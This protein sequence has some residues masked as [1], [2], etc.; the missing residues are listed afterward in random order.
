MRNWAGRKEFSEVI[1]MNKLKFTETLDLALN[2]TPN[3]FS[4]I[5]L[6]L[7]KANETLYN[8]YQQGE[9]IGILLE[10][11]SDLIDHVLRH[12][13]QQHRLEAENF[14]ALIAVGGYGRKEMHPASD[15][16]LLVLLPADP[17]EACQERLSNFITLLWDIGLDIGHSVRT[18]D[19]C[20]D[21]AKN[22]LTVITNLIESR[23]LI[24][25]EKT[26]KALQ[27]GISPDNLWSSK[28]FLQAKL[29]EQVTRYQKYGKTAYRVEP[30]L[31]EG[32][33]GLR[34]IQVIVWVIQRH[35]GVLSLHE[36]KN[37]DFLSDDEYEELSV[38]RDFLWEIRFV[39]HQ[40]SGR[41]EDR[42]LFQY[43][44]K[45]AEAF[46]YE[47]NTANKAVEEFMMRYYR[48]ITN[49]DRLNTLLL[50]LLKEKIL[51]PHHTQHCI[52]NEWYEEKNGLI[53]IRNPQLFEKQPH[54]LLEI[55]LILQVTP[56]ATG[57]T[58]NTV[59][60]IRQNLHL[61]DD[62]FRN[63]NDCKRIFIEIMRQQ[64]GVTLALKHMNQYGVL[65][66]YI[67]IFQGIVG[68]MQ[69][70]LYHAFT[71]DDH[72]L[73]VIR[74]V[75]RYST[76]EGEDELPL[77]SQIFSTL[78]KPELLY[79]A[80]LFHDI[81][82]GRGGDHAELGAI[83]AYNFCRSHHLDESDA[84]IVSWL[85]KNHLLLSIIVQKKDISDPDVINDFADRVISVQRLSYLYLLTVAD[86]RGT[87]LKLWTS[88]KHSLLQQF[89]ISVKNSLQS[90]HK[91]TEE[92]QK[93]KLQKK[94][95]SALAKLMKK[96]FS[97]DACEKLWSNLDAS[98]F[99]QHSEKTLC[100]HTE[101][102]LSDHQLPLLKLRNSSRNSTVIFIY[103]KDDPQLFIRTVATLEKLNINT[104]EAKIT[105]SNNGFDLYT[106][107]VLD[108]NGS[109]LTESHDQKI[110]QEALKHNLTTDTLPDAS[111]QRISSELKHLDVPTDIKFYQNTK[112]A[113]TTLEIETGDRPGLL[114]LLG[115]ALYQQHVQ[116]QDARITTLEEQ[117]QD[118]FQITDFEGLPIVDKTKLDKI[119][120][121]IETMLE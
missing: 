43:Q 46:G 23:L 3:D 32:P 2:N 96:G 38:S 94:K 62:T 30:N 9:D 20:L 42:L 61:I 35:Y 75:R 6:A 26:Y 58:P 10:A 107:H 53:A 89:Y 120:V 37:H 47:D 121:A 64:K 45:L 5:K 72:T 8:T 66:A 17:D 97:S 60:N 88:W 103:Q 112:K 63:N 115:K 57:L 100:W 51:N 110:L 14:A 117:V 78:I 68:R 19:E 31:K 114:S 82:K 99:L 11:R 71:V 67:P 13:W 119:K 16:D 36:L 4:A 102:I 90:K 108:A 24:G 109:A 106:L 85:V 27:A 95:I 44:Q 101:S 113:W 91:A 50:N 21:E 79:L 12:Y 41:K 40:L 98:Y 73:H 76:H 92:D 81:A 93:T 80:A 18:L 39:L 33:G 7:K 49:L 65:A 116:I 77:C 48:T 105:S 111:K 84:S 104:V 55:F 15:I 56:K 83:D 70:D 25:H 29:E 1:K 87:N 54:T 52:I 22:D 69:F 74:N 28:D 86:I 34:D 118:V 59:R